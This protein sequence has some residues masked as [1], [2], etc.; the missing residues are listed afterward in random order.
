MHREGFR[1]QQDNITPQRRAVLRAGRLSVVLVATA[2]TVGVGP[3]Q[4]SLV[5][6]QETPISHD[7]G[8]S[9]TP[10]FEGWFRNTEGTYNLV[11]G[12][13]NRNFKQVLD[14]PVGPNNR[15]TPGPDDQGQPTH[16][17]TRRHWGVFA[18]AVPEANFKDPN[19][20]LTWTIV[21]AGQTIAIPGHF[22][23]EWEIDA[24]REAANGNTPPLI[25]L[26]PDGKTAQGPAGVS[27]RLQ[28]VPL[29]PVTLKVWATD[30][31]IKKPGQV[32]RPSKEAPLGVGWSKYSGPGKVVFANPDPPLE[33][34]V[35][36]TTATFSDPGE[37]VLR[38]HAWDDSG[39]YAGGFYC[40][41]T[42]GYARVSV[43][44]ATKTQ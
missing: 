10:A 22:R 9:V 35:A 23:P 31:G 14:I 5:S 36:T 39:R 28:T 32:G 24:L 17:M 33:G 18:V 4:F 11:F 12:Y 29:T 25:K 1:A 8:Q 42:N 41:W 2:L 40:C 20:K 16:F 21:S 43:R 30:D 6:A 34:G 7:S 44:S 15:L 13:M 19:F 38:M 26:A 37:Y 3:V 27:I